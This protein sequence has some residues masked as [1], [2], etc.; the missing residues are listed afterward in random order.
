MK[1]F[2]AITA[3]ASHQAATAA[4]TAI[5]AIMASVHRRAFL[6][7]LSEDIT[8]LRDVSMIPTLFGISADTTVYYHSKVYCDLYVNMFF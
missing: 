8:V 5:N 6:A 7:E 4:N 3:M 2:A 1:S